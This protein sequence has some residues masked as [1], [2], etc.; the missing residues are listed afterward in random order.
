MDFSY[1][2]SSYLASIIYNAVILTALICS[3]ISNPCF[4]GTSSIFISSSTAYNQAHPKSTL[5]TLTHHPEPSAASPNSLTD[6]FSFLARF[7]R[8]D[9]QRHA[10]GFGAVYKFD[11]SHDY[12]SEKAARDRYH[13]EMSYLFRN[14]IRRHK[15]NRNEHTQVVF[16]QYPCLNTVT[17]THKQHDSTMNQHLLDTRREAAGAR[18]GARALDSAVHRSHPH[19]HRK[20]KDRRQVLHR[21]PGRHANVMP[22]RYGYDRRCDH[23]D[24]HRSRSKS[25]SSNRHRNNN[26]KSD[27]TLASSILDT[28]PALPGLIIAT[29]YACFEDMEKLVAFFYNG[30]ALA[31]LMDR[32]QDTHM[33]YRIPPH[34]LLVLVAS[35]LLVRLAL[36]LVLCLG[37]FYYCVT[38]MEQQQRQIAGVSGGVGSNWLA[39]TTVES[40]N[41]TSTASSLPS[42]DTAAREHNVPA[43][44][45]GQYVSLRANGGSGSEDTATASA[46]VS[47]ISSE[48]QSLPAG[49]LSALL[50][51]TAAA[52]TLTCGSDL[53]SCSAST[54]PA[55]P[56]P[57]VFLAQ[58]NSQGQESCEKRKVLTLKED[59]TDHPKDAQDT[60]SPSFESETFGYYMSHQLH[61]QQSAG[62]SSRPGSRRSSISPPISPTEAC[63]LK[64]PT[65]TRRKCSGVESPS[66]PDLSQSFR[67]HFY[68]IDALRAT[69]HNR[70]STLGQCNSKSASISCQKRRRRR[71]HRVSFAARGGQASGRR[72]TMHARARRDRARA[73]RLAGTGP[74]YE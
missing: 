12:G 14:R 48:P 71:R 57:A 9:D 64:A 28:L 20:D 15:N 35:N 46:P 8:E 55:L 1:R 10:Q 62:E 7:F 47:L 60:F 22:P 44:Q 51:S 56:H 23:S 43:E 17:P 69:V 26:S 21:S 72:C 54:T 38:M 41:A 11:D 73:A 16:E 4:L 32:N 39:D 36:L 18:P 24:P 5:P 29:L 65:S 74:S 33:P 53:L 70:Y 27:R 34:P 30:G 66:A 59:G 52:L 63:S 50:R 61:H 6:V 37:A 58:S 67:S 3:I 49:I 25:R 42:P 2:V 19:Q 40:R 13:R 31:L 68:C 45:S